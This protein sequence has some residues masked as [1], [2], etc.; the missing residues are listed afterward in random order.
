MSHEQLNKDK[1]TNVDSAG[2]AASA[3]AQLGATGAQVVAG[4]LVLDTRA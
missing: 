3:H 2:Q 4:A 1:S